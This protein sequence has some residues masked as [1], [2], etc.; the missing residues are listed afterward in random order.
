[1]DVPLLL[2]AVSANSPCGEDLEYDADFLQLERDALGKPERSMG[3]AVQQAEPPNWRL[4]EQSSTALLQR[5]KD[6]RVTHFLL[7]SA[8]ALDGVLGLASVLTLINDLLGQYWATLHPQLD[9]E[10]DND[11]TVRINALA[12]IACETNVRLLRESLLGLLS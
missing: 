1:M 3:D 4:I 12:G 10:D 6:L 9:A 7:Q 2:A 11:P 8:L 5:S